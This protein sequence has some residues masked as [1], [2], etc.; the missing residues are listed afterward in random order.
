MPYDLDSIEAKLGA[1]DKTALSDEALAFLGARFA[2]NDAP[3]PAPTAGGLS[4]LEMLDSPYAIGGASDPKTGLVAY[5]IFALGFA[6]CGCVQHAMMTK[7]P[8]ATI[9]AAAD[10]FAAQKRV[11]TPAAAVLIERA[12]RKQFDMATTAFNFFPRIKGDDAPP[13]VFGAEWLAAIVHAASLCNIAP[14]AALWE[15]PLITLAFLRVQVARY[16]GAKNVDR[17]NT[18]NWSAALKELS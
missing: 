16:D 6:A 4:L 15:M 18:L 7:D 5:F 17:S 3:L 14:H 11:G 8:A 10:R 9:A 13:L 12:Y 2:V 1:P